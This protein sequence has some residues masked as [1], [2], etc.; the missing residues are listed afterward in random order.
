MRGYDLTGKVFNRLTVI[1]QVGTN[2]HGTKLWL[3]QCVCGNQTTVRTGHLTS[4]S[5]SSCGCLYHEDLTGKIFGELVA[6]ERM[7]NSN[8]NKTTWKCECSCGNIKNVAAH[9]LKSG[10]VTSCGCKK[11]EIISKK[12]TR[13]GM[14]HSKEHE[15]WCNMRRRCNDHSNIQYPHYGGRGI[16]VCDRWCGNDGFDNFI[17]DMGKCPEGKS[18]ID[19]IDNDGPYSPENCRWATSIEQANNRS[20]NRRV[21]FGGDVMTVADLSRRLNVDY[22]VVYRLVQRGVYANCS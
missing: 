12:K 19:R 22:E 7:E 16:Q 20:N 18:S 5:V 9:H 21:S 6:I 14:C 17:V 1:S 4:G 15:A 2:Q 10:G 8:S 3:C 13:H 11:G